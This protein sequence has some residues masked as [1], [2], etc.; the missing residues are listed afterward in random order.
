MAETAQPG[1]EEAVRAA[2]GTGVSLKGLREQVADL[3]VDAALEETG[4]TSGR[5]GPA[6]CHRARAPSASR[7]AP[8]LTAWSARRRELV[9]QRGEELVVR[10]AG[11]LGVHLGDLRPGDVRPLVARSFGEVEG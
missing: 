3:A 1:L 5:G 10:R 6:R 8:R 9:R 2:V 7:P 11:Q 4:G